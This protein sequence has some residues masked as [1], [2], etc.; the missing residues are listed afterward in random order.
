MTLQQVFEAIDLMS[1]NELEQ[2]RAR[3]DQ[4]RLKLKQPGPQ[5]PEE[6]R[7]ALEDAIDAAREGLTEDQISQ[8]ADAIEGKTS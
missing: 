2:V 1:L 5:D 3:I 8:I 4:V 6:W 7:Q